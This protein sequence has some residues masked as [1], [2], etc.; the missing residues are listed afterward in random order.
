ML[1]P[2]ARASGDGVPPLV[3]SDMFQDEIELELAANPPSKAH[4]EPI[5]VMSYDRYI[6]A[7]SGGKDSIACLLHLLE[8]GVPK[9]RI[10]VHHH[11]VDGEPTGEDGLMD[12]PVTTDYCRKV[13]EAFGLRF[14]LSWRHGGIERELMRNNQPTAP[15][16]IPYLVDGKRM[17]VGGQ[18]KPN[19]RLKFPQQSSNLSVR[20][21]SSVAKISLMDA[22]ISNDP[23]FLEGRTLVITGE[24]AE[25]SSSR[26]HYHEF[27]PHR[28]DNRNGARVRRLVDHWRPVHKW[29]EHQV[30][31][32]IKRWRVVPHVGYSLGFGRL[33]CRVCV[34][35]SK[36][37]WATVKFIAPS[38]FK[39]V[40]TLEAFTGLTIH[41]AKSVEEQASCGRVYPASVDPELIAVANSHVYTLEVFTD[42]WVL[43][44]GAFGEASGPT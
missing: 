34:F 21:C 18:G 19:T 14:S 10:E 32:I 15:V 4:K 35:A 13:A 7:M 43:P 5:D 30:W 20:W 23:Q 28:K 6:V 2:L 33:S 1:M 24:R 22:W 37:Q 36:D 29:T 17:D 39:R 42:N 26:A 3:Q 41:R 44:A 38:Q 40:S 8:C 11:C 9:D 16:S 31:G 12:W 27:E 25:E